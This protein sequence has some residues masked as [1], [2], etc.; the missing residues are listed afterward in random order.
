MGIK[1]FQFMS[2]LKSNQA[3]ELQKWVKN[4]KNGSK[5]SYHQV[6]NLKPQHL[7]ATFDPGLP[8]TAKYSHPWCAFN[9]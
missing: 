3:E 6:G 1:H 4:T 7:Q 8:K 5:W 2:T 9:D